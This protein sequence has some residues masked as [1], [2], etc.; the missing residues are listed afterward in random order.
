MPRIAIGNIVGSNIAN[1]LL[2]VGLTSLADP[3]L[4]RDAPARY[5]C[6][7]RCGDRIGADICNGRD[8]STA[9]RLAGPRPSSLPDGPTCNP[10]RPVMTTLTRLLRPPCS[11]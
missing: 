9:G 7:G 3:S 4:W 6:H 10:A 8:R 1:T 5:G 11:S 2:I